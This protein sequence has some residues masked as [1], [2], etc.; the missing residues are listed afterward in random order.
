VVI[1]ISINYLN[2]LLDILTVD[3]VGVWKCGSHWK[4]TM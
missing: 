2:V 3:L 4:T 1:N